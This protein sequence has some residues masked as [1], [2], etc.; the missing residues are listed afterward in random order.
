MA[1]DFDPDAFL[2]EQEAGDFD[3]DAFL[4]D[5][6]S[7]KPAGL[8][9]LE[10]IS[11]Y[12]DAPTRAALGNLVDT[13]N[14]L[15]AAGAFKDAWGSD[16]K[17]APTGTQIA[18]KLGISDKEL[19]PTLAKT[20][21]GMM[22]PLGAGLAEP[23][24]KAV[25][26]TNADVVGTGIDF[27]ADWTNIPFGGAMK[28]AGSA[29]KM[30][31]GAVKAG[32]LAQK[33]IAVPGKLL[34][35]VASTVSGVP[36]TTIQTFSKNADEVLDLYKTKDGN[37]AEIADEMRG[38]WNKNV[39][40]AKSR[41]YNRINKSLANRPDKVAS[42]PILEALSDVKAG[43]DPDLDA[44]DIAEIEEIAA[45]L[46]KKGEALDLPTLLKVKVYLQDQAAPAYNKGG[47]IFTRGKKAARAAQA[48]AAKARRILNDA[49]PDVAMDN[50]N[51]SQLHRLEKS[52]NRNLLKE[53]A[54]HASIVQAGSDAGS[55]T[56]N[57]LKR[58][59]QFTEQDMLGDAQ[60]LAAAK[61][62]GEANFNPL[63]FTGKAVGRMATGATLGYLADGQDGAFIGGALSNPAAVKYGILL[64][65][66]GAA[67]AAQAGRGVQSVAASAPNA[68][69]ILQSFQAARGAGR[70]MVGGNSS[71]NERLPADSD[72]IIGED[73]ARERFK[74]G[75]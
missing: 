18:T 48:G 5:E 52:F 23:A 42:K 67:K 69:K 55:A 1:D 6:P 16:P 27:G 68:A 72:R 33:A 57:S 59:G 49:A 2:A 50:M 44:S 29:A 3:P 39:Q 61:T 36:E 43:L 14:P 15:A 45:T 28:L 35:K 19:S 7:K 66:L 51:L 22:G 26:A 17:T 25:D 70:V 34:T 47:Q 60:N 40:L 53:G 54:S 74:K 75:N 32:E 41:V 65:R 10:T 31:P 4:A 8:S 64:K 9:A 21:G 56:G 30:A 12:T 58:L 63:D 13:G 73:E 46:A 62:F 37:I 38:K 24:L 11:S 20:V 71:E